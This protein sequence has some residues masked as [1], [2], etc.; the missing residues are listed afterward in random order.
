MICQFRTDRV[1]SKMS[2]ARQWPNFDEM[3]LLLMN[4]TIPHAMNGSILFI[5]GLGIDR[6]FA[7]RRRKAPLVIVAKC[8]TYLHTIGTYLPIFSRAKTTHPPI[9]T[10]HL[11]S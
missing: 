4:G 7:S 6:G 3:E 9:T 8:P 11:P 5:N 10:N 1:F 2:F